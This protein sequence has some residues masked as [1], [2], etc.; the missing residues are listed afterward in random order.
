MAKRDKAK[1]CRKA[2]RL[3]RSSLQPLS[4]E[5]ALRAPMQVKPRAQQK[6]GAKRRKAKRSKC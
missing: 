4:V 6:Q 3:K 1:E 5:D 2:K